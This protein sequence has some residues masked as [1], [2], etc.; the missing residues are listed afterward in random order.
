MTW[1]RRAYNMDEI[2]CVGDRVI[3]I[4]DFFHGVGTVKSVHQTKRGV[5]ARVLP[6]SAEDENGWE[7]AHVLNLERVD[8]DK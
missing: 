3:S 5:F 1:V 4:S 2:P 7:L 8:K 6:D